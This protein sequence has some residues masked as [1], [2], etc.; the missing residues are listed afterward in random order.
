M[1]ISRRPF[2]YLPILFKYGFVE[3]LVRFFK[4]ETLIVLKSDDDFR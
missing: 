4:D 1:A 3:S 2:R